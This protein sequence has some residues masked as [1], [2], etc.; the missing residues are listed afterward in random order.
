VCSEMGTVDTVMKNDFCVLK[1][2]HSRH[3]D[4]DL[5]VFTTGYIRHSDKEMTYVS[6]QWAQ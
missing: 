4:K 5:L 6:L 3:S 1:N 2:G